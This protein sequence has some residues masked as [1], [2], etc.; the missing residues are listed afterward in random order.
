M[1][2]LEDS[3]CFA[4]IR[5]SVCARVSVWKFYFAG[6]ENLRAWCRVWRREAPPEPLCSSIMVTLV[7]VSSGSVW[8]LNRRVA[9]L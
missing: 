3:G 4:R 5:S 6:L 7:V 1:A 2:T 9:N 8:G